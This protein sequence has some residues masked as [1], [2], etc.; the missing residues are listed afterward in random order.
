LTEPH[1]QPEDQ[2][3]EVPERLIHLLAGRDEFTTLDEAALDLASVFAPRVDRDGTLRTLDRWA[4]DIAAQLSPSAGGAEFVSKTNRY[5]FEQQGLSG[6]SEDYFDPRNSLLDQVVA[7]RKGMPISLAVVYLEISRRL[8][9]PVYG[10]GLPAHF[11]VRYHDGLVTLFVDCFHGR[12]LTRAQ[13]LD[14][15][16]GLTGQRPSDDDLTFAACTPRQ[17]LSRMA[18]NLARSCEQRD[19]LVPALRI[20]GLLGLAESLSSSPRA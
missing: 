10:V 11:M 19:L 15:V 20:R 1:T 9:R 4:D 2:R 3:I 16:Q 8:L 5:L 13:C 14:L 12:T 6:D 7:R 17:I 18:R